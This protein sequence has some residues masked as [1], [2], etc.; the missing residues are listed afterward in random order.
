MEEPQNAHHRHRRPRSSP[1]RLA[2][3]RLLQP[4]PT[5]APNTGRG[6]WRRRPS[7]LLRRGV[8]GGT[9]ELVAAGSARGKLPDGAVTA[10]AL[11]RGGHRRRRFER[12]RGHGDRG[13]WN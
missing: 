13:K 7:L 12:E 3:Q 9:V 4:L 2:P 5:P 11:G 1:S 6:G 10:A 8:G